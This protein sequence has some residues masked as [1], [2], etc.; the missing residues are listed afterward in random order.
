[1]ETENYLD[2]SFAMLP[3]LI[4]LIGIPVAL[5]LTVLPFWF[6]CKKAG[7]HGALSLLM[8]VPIA[9]VILPFFLAFAEWPALRTTGK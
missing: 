5:L 3:L 4:L 9:N 6:I 1:M 2:T 8:L 7:F